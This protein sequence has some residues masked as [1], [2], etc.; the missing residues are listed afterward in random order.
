MDYGIVV[1]SL[2]TSCTWAQKDG[3]FQI[4]DT[5]CLNYGMIFQNLMLEV[6]LTY[7]NLLL[8]LLTD[9][10]LYIMNIIP[11]FKKCIATIFV[12]FKHSR[13]ASVQF[14]LCRQKF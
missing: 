7:G 8:I 4:M 2:K 12:N 6:Q 14:S 11:V 3:V 9:S 5:L 13:F 10:Y 1:D